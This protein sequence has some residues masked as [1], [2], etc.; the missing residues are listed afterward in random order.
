MG[1]FSVLFYFL[2]FTYPISL[3]LS[4]GLC[5]LEQDQVHEKIH[6][7]SQAKYEDKVCEVVSITTM[8]F[9]FD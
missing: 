2:F 7:K 8:E 6:A 1:E 9:T 4:S 5:Y 3:N